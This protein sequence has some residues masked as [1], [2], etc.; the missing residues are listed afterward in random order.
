MNTTRAFTF[1]GAVVIT[2]LVLGVGLAAMPA[3]GGVTPEIAATYSPGGLISLI[4]AAFLVAFAAL[5]AARAWRAGRF[6]ISDR[7]AGLAELI[8]VSAYFALTTIIVDWTAVS[9]LFWVVSV[10]VTAAGAGVL[11]LRF[12]SLPWRRTGNRFVLRVIRLVIGMLASGAVIAVA[13]T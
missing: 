9:L 13:L 4:P 3:A 11:A 10:G 8:G 6:S 1:A 7:V 12:L 5:F 2:G